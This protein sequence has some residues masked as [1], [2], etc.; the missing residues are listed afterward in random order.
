[1]ILFVTDVAQS[2]CS[3]Q[4]GG[5]DEKTGPLDEVVPGPW[6]WVA[7]DGREP[8][9]T[10]EPGGRELQWRDFFPAF[11]S[12]IVWADDDDGGDGLSG[13]V[14]ARLTFVTYPHCWYV[15][16]TSKVKAK[17]KGREGRSSEEG[18]DS[19][20]HTPPPPP[21]LLGGKDSRS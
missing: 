4:C 18:R 5:G 2:P 7:K 10:R 6:T 21:P 13:A 3:N 16:I 8:S 14:C 20:Y 17:V 11:V 19:F 12:G 15:E 1:L 9:F